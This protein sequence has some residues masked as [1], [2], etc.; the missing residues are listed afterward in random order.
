MEEEVSYE[1]QLVETP[2]IFGGSLDILKL[3]I[4][5]QMARVC[6]AFES[7]DPEKGNEAFVFMK[8]ATHIKMLDAMILSKTGKDYRSERDNL[9]RVVEKYEKE[10]L[11]PP[12]GMVADWWFYLRPL[13]DWYGLECSELSNLGLVPI[14]RLSEPWIV[15]SKKYDGE[16]YEIQ[17]G[18]EED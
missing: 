13:M 3:N 6:R 11:H 15:N 1:D 17:E 12:E 10:L 5:N 14:D 4:G 16:K 9:L 2:Q 18:P 7:L 8:A